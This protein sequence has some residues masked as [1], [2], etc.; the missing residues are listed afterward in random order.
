MRSK[1]RE[2]V[3]E[4]VIYE[5]FGNYSIGGQKVLVLIESGG[6]LTL[7]IHSGFLLACARSFYPIRV[8]SSSNIL[9][10]LLSSNLLY[11]DN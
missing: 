5:G 3:Q 2:L 11:S 6:T 10:Y 9:C 4:H 7:F 8:S 1:S